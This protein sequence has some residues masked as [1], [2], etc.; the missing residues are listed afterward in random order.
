MPKRAKRPC[1]FPGC[2]QLVSV[3]DGGLCEAHRKAQDKKYKRERT[4]KDEQL[5]YTS[6][7]WRKL[8]KMQ[9]HRHPLCERCES[10]GRVTP[11]TLVH[12]R[13]EVKAGGE[14][15]DMQNLAS[16]CVP[17]HESMHRR[18]AVREASERS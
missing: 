13:T 5:L 15:F 7:Q 6:A 3:G 4:D 14:R 12:H 1:S 18:G 10:Q 9:L 2:A 8:R 16:L 11:A 17:C